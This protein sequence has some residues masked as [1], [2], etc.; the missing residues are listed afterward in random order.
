MSHKASTNHQRKRIICVNLGLVSSYLPQHR[1]VHVYGPIG[2]GK[3]QTVWPYTNWEC[4][5]SVKILMKDRHRHKYPG[6]GHLALSVSGVTVA[7]S[8]VSSVF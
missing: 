2:L 1:N 3:V 8:I 6:L 5:I 4:R 7:L